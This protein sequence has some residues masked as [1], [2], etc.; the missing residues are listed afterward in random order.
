M[1]C[2]AEADRQPKAMPATCHGDVEAAS[3]RKAGNG[4]RPYAA[5]TMG[6]RQACAAYA[7]PW[8]HAS[9]AGCAV[10]SKR[11]E[12]TPKTH[13][14]GRLKSIS[15]E[16]EKSGAHAS[17]CQVIYHLVPWSLKCLLSCQMLLQGH[18]YQL[19]ECRG[20]P[21]CLPSLCRQSKRDHNSAIRRSKAASIAAVLGS[22][23][24]I[25]TLDQGWQLAGK[26]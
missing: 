22:S 13:G 26:R 20:E 24:G 15:A 17:A 1:T 18:I 6:M 23:H 11:C 7:R 12:N 5:A 3:Q 2:T 14:P 4:I 9:R 10:S 25:V 21:K 8:E 19:L 16:A